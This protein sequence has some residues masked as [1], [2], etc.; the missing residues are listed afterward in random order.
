VRAQLRASVSA[1]PIRYL[2]P[3]QST[4][5]A[6]VRHADGLAVGLRDGASSWPMNGDAEGLVRPPVALTNEATTTTEMIGGMDART[7][8]A[9][10][11][12]MGEHGH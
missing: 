2:L 7:A 9:L 12:D 3:S 4:R 6:F 10:P 5:A 8:S 1:A 11:R